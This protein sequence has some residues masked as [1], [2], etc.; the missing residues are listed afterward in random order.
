MNSPAP[1]DCGCRADAAATEAQRRILQIALMLNAAMFL[2]G[3]AAGVVSRSSSL[4]AD[5]VD[6]LADASAY[7]IALLA[8][9]RS[10]LFKA[11]AARLSG[12]LLILLGVGVLGDALRRA[13]AGHEPEGWVIIFVASLS[14][15]V[16]LTV[17]RLLGRMRDQGVHLRAAWLFTRVDVI[18]NLGVMG[19][20]VVMLLT[21]F[22]FVD[23]IVG[24]AIGL[25]VIKEGREI[26][27][28]GGEASDTA[29]RQSAGP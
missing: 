5:S 22:S 1:P 19:S 28:E 29:K 17:L 13:F 25:Y 20:G 26:L 12:T 4:I 27:R 8:V 6:M 18:A 21:R 7:A 14:L 23:I 15:A 24:A 10:E 9:G 11:R 3:V 16:N 2:V